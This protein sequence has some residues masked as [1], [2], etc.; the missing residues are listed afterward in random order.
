ML[1][2]TLNALT[3]QQSH[4]QNQNCKMVVIKEVIVCRWGFI[5]C[6]DTHTDKVEEFHEVL[7]GTLQQRQVMECCCLALLYMMCI[8]QQQLSNL[9]HNSFLIGSKPSYSLKINGCEDILLFRAVCSRDRVCLISELRCEVEV[10]PFTAQIS[11][12]NMLKFLF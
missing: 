3:D 1:D 10:N 7:S 4:T 5:A 9:F 8:E 11:K 2:F 12:H 6:Y